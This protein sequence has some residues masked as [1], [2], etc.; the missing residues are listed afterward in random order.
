MC[1]I[2]VVIFS[3]GTLVSRMEDLKPLNTTADSSTENG[4]TIEARFRDFCKVLFRSF[5]III[6]YFDIIYVILS[7]V[8]FVLRFLIHSIYFKS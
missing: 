2:F 5:V 1:P 6:F 7:F 4:A 8:D 3:T